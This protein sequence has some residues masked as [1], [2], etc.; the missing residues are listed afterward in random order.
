ML[1]LP[2]IF[3]IKTLRRQGETREYW[4]IENQSID[5][6]GSHMNRH[7]SS[8]PSRAR[9]VASGQITNTTTSGTNDNDVLNNNNQVIDLSIP[10][11][12]PNNAD[13]DSDDSSFEYDKVSSD[14]SSGID[15]DITFED[16]EDDNDNDADA[17]N[18]NNAGNNNAG[19]SDS[20][21]PSIS[22]LSNISIDETD[23]N[24]L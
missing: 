24:E 23:F 12:L 22:G 9:V 1:L 13:I 6:N 20:E 8:S 4:D 14:Y 18:N 5:N 11:Q 19:N 10:I 21:H 2:L 7:P 3:C 16:D 15:R 17:D